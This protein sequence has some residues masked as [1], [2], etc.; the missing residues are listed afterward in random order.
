MLIELIHAEILLQAGDH[1]V[2]DHVGPPSVQ[3]S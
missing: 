3:L 2:V 1:V